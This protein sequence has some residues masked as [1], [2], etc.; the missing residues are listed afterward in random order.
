MKSIL[1]QISCIFACWLMFA[2]CMKGPDRD[3][4]KRIFVNRPLL[5]MFVDEEVQVTASPTSETFTW[6]SENSSVATVSQTGLVRATG[7]GETNIIVS[8]GDLQRVIPVK[9]IVKIPV[10]NI[11]VSSAS[12]RL[13]PGEVV[14]L[15]ASLL[16][17]NH[18]E[19]E[20][21]IIV[22]ETSDPSVATV[23]KGTVRAINSGDAIITVK[24]ERNPS[25]KK[26]VPVRVVETVDITNEVLTNTGMPFEYVEPVSGY[27]PAVRWCVAADWIA[28]ETA[29]Q[30]GNMD[31]Q[32][33]TLSL[34]ANTTTALYP[35][36]INGKMYQ[37]V[38]LEA[39][40]YKF[41][42]SLFLTNL[43]AS[44][45]AYIVAALGDE[46]PDAGN[47][48]Q[49]L[50]YTPFINGVGEADASKPT[51]SIQFTISE[52]S[53]VS[54]GFLVNYSGGATNLS[55][56]SKVVLWNIR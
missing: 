43:D 29:V 28:N 19:K 44:H 8:C 40:I 15:M 23:S 17:E 26:E 52:K 4:E 10:T 21:N 33:G 31:S 39:G 50:A 18:N 9:A 51:I 37:T 47:V 53:V 34:W 3:I 5:D 45:R 48:A 12:L 56:I 6:N 24:L 38:E 20:S 13:F 14:N 7:A 36:I 49:A 35:T 41:D 30:N 1:F 46:L 55:H 11:S 16:P 42:V 2:G 32:R 54:L 27:A 22:W 25:I